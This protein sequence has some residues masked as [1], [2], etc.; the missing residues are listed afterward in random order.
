MGNHSRRGFLACTRGWPIAPELVYLLVSS[1][2]LGSNDDGL[3]HRCQDGRHHGGATR[4]DADEQPVPGDFGDRVR[5]GPREDVRQ[6]GIDG[7]GAASIGGEQVYQVGFVHWW[8]KRESE[9]RRSVQLGY[10]VYLFRGKS[11]V[12]NF[13]R[14]LPC[15]IK[16]LCR[17]RA[18]AYP[19]LG[20]HYEGLGE[21][22]CRLLLYERRQATRTRAKFA[23]LV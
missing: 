15:F 11:G 18:D 21:R 14:S 2:P 4:N 13:S 9:Y 10:G 19:Y 8:Y 22:R 20:W 3:Y 7:E 5:R 12:F 16:A 23:P 17:G 1:P 6:A